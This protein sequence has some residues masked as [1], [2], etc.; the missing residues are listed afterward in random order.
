M[1]IDI[2]P[3]RNSPPAILLREC[4]R[5][6]GVVKKRTIANLSAVPIPIVLAP[7]DMLK[8]GVW[9]PYGQEVAIE[10]SR[11]HGAV[12]AMLAVL[13]RTGLASALAARRSRERDICVALIAER[14]L[15]G[16]S[17][18]AS[19]R[20]WHTTSLADELR[21]ANVKVADVYAALDWLGARQ[22]AIEK[23]LARAH[24][25]DGSLVLYDL[26]SSYYESCHCPL[27][28]FGYSRD[29]KRGLPSI[30][31]GVITDR[32]GR[33]VAVRVWEGNVADQATVREQVQRVRDAFGIARITFVGDRGMLTEARIEALR[34]QP[35]VQW[36]SA[37]RSEDVRTLVAAGTVQMS[38]LHLYGIAEVTS[39]EF[40]GERLIVCYNP[41]MADEPTRTRAALMACTEAALNALAASAARRGRTPMS[42]AELGQQ[43]DRIINKW[44]M[45]K[46][47]VS[48]IH[49]GRL[50][51]SWNQE[52][53]AR[54]TALDGL[55]IVRTNVPAQDLSAADAVRGYLRLARV[56]RAF[57]CMMDM[58]NRVQPSY[59]RTPQRVHAHI[60]LCLLAYYAEWHLRDALKEYLFDDEE[61]AQAR[62]TR[63]A[64]APAT[65]SRRARAK[66]ARAA[67]NPHA[68]HSVSTLFE[69]LN[70]LCRHTCR[71]NVQGQEVR[72]TVETEPT[73]WQSAVLARLEGRERTQ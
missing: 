16:E 43:V 46:H 51:W 15:H 23:K 11:P 3:N 55:S 49:A 4:Y 60:F 52:R 56:A 39:D 47:V 45:A 17:N 73:A 70:T 41:L 35:W 5:E 20:L 59:H 71:F 37:L 63:D 69:E 54:E 44:K 72:Y 58:N 2:V 25:A 19:V 67:V 26:T 18:L 10:H 12:R 8:S 32:D 57:R 48:T 1:Y 28:Q 64:V 40:P 36:I 38:L 27:A 42:D 68:V 14:L 24:L 7:R 31:Y 30:T 33:P 9:V 21:L 62:D 29:G 61:L 65:P 34:W 50:T 53:I 66:K 6:H 22:A 13:Q